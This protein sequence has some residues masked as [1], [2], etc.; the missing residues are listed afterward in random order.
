MRSKLL[1]LMM[2]IFAMAALSGT[3]HA[4]FYTD[5]GFE[6]G[7]G[8]LPDAWG[9]WSGYGAGTYEYHIN[10][11]VAKTGEDCME[12]GSPAGASGDFQWL[13]IDIP[14]M[15]ENT[16]Y[17]AGGYFKDILSGGSIGKI[18][19]AFEWW[20]TRDEDKISYETME[21]TIPND[22]AW[23]WV[24]WTRTSPPGTL[25][26]APMIGI[27]GN[28]ECAYL[29][30]DVVF[31]AAGAS[32]PQ[33]AHNSKVQAPGT[34][35]L[36]WENSTAETCTIYWNDGAPDVNDVNFQ[37]HIDVPTGKV[38]V[39]G[40]VLNDDPNQV[41]G[42]VVAAGRNYCWR[43]D[44]GSQGGGVWKFSTINDPPDVDAGPKQALWLDSVP[45][46]VT[47]QLAPTVT[48]DGLPVPPGALTYLWTK[49]AG[50]GVVTFTPSAVVK[51][52]TAS[53]SVADDYELTLT[54]SDGG[55]TPGSDTVKI[56]VHA[57]GTTGLE[58]RYDMDE[59]VAAALVHDDF[60]GNLR[61]GDRMADGEIE[62][63]GYTGTEFDITGGHCADGGGPNVGAMVFYPGVPGYVQFPNSGNDPNIPPKTPGWADFRDEVSLAAWIKVDT[64]NGGWDDNWESVINK[65]E[66][67]YRL[68]RNAGGDS[69]QMTVNIDDAESVAEGTTA[70][71]DGE[72]HHVMGTYDGAEV[73]IYVD[74]LLDT[75][76][77]ECVEA[78]GQI[79]WPLYDG[80]D[81]TIGQSLQNDAPFGGIMDEVRIHS[82]GLP[83][84]SDN[85][86]AAL[87]ALTARSVISIYRTSCG[88]T[89]CGGVY[90]DGDANG[91][92]YVNMDDVKLMAQHWLECNSIALERC[93]DFWR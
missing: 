10:D 1:F 37:Y 75:E 76:S 89:N 57:N 30:D 27:E 12:V 72:W 34:V 79:D 58:G 47:F 20:I 29:L 48:D 59:G 87:T 2:L 49:T 54:V 6:E 64:E 19:I 67:S 17:T 41:L 77:G 70:V 14:D 55:P 39:I 81:L 92:C 68:H 33:P 31:R 32:N 82:I 8:D 43:V 74:G 16:G 40:T 46:P 61:H 28:G 35:D 84:A 36:K 91:D 7:S 56:R 44:V 26:I 63:S 4:N 42:K 25:M 88:H 50:T 11:A 15:S 23:H 38:T 60:S 13:F 90:I 86:E 51:A 66:G 24:E 83:H 69:I 21:F 3:V 18:Q 53:M 65:G 52:P 78:E 80:S 9:E 22:G 62:T 45:N 93:D 71:N 85:P 5:P 73:C